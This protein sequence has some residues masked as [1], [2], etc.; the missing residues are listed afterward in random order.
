MRQGLAVAV[1]AGMVLMTA[2]SAQA[3]VVTNVAGSLTYTATSGEANRVLLEREGDG[4]RITDSGADVLFGLP[5]CPSAGPNSIRCEGVGAATVALGDGDDIL[6]VVGELRVTADGGPGA[7]W[8]AG[9]ALADQ[10]DGGAGDDR[11]TGGEGADRIDGGAGR[12]TADYTLRTTPVV[13]TLDGIENDGAPGELD[14][15]IGIEAVLGGRAGDVIDG[16]D[17]P[18]AIFGGPGNDSLNGGGGTDEI[19]GG[20]GQDGVNALDPPAGPGGAGGAGPGEGDAGAGAETGAGASPPGAGAD[21]IA[22]GD[23]RDRVYG[24]EPDGVGSDCEKVGRGAVAG[25]SVGSRVS[26]AAP[27]PVLGHSVVVEPISGVIL[28]T[29]PEPGSPPRQKQDVPAAPAVP[30]SAETNIPVGSV[31]DTRFGTV[32]LTV[33]VDRADATESGRFYSGPFQVFQDD[34]VGT[35]A[36]LELRGGKS[37][38]GCPPGQKGP[39]VASASKRRKVVRRLWAEA[40]GRFRTKGRFA[41]ATVRGTRWMTADRCDGTLVSVREGAVTVA[42]LLRGGSTIVR[43]GQSRLVRR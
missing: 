26:P 4:L 16:D 34:V 36:D 18:N 38:A 1:A 42:D 22:C 10:L 7:D 41:A 25:V 20:D 27:P 28:V 19:D 8:L 33:A 35:G 30:L 15:V 32:E 6:S 9:G 24:D 29:P 39:G 12:D 14:L 23:G 17:G 43:A 13:V 3:A 2:T 37:F 31:V 40:R 11:V 21:Q 5:G